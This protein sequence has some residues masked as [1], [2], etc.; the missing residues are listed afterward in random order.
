MVRR[1]SAGRPLT[2]IVDG[3][4]YGPGSEAWRLNREAMLLLGAGPRALLLQIAHPLVAAGVAEHSDFQA[5]PWTRLSGT[6]RSYLRI[7]YGSAETA[8]G[9]IRR[10]GDLH[11]GIRG[12]VLDPIA[13]ERHG[14]RYSALDPQLALWVHA[15]LVDSTIAAYDAWLEPLTRAQRAR[16]YAETLPVGRAFGIPE[17]ILPPDLDAFDSYLAE[18]LAPGGPI[19]V[20]PEARELA[21]AITHPPLGPAAIAAGP[22]LARLAPMLD[23]IPSRAYSWLFWPSIGLLPARVREGYGLPWGLRQRIVATWL[24]STWQAWR[25]MLPQTFRQ[26]PQAIRADRRVGAGTPL[27]PA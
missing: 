26:M 2:S 5:D 1:T 23:G 27:L 19:E 10:L 17:A 13:R 16:Y 22:I 18:M 11:R 6:L 25:P 9:E 15:T 20:G 8:R 7:V 12:D 4:F 14:R 21:N 3:G 24:V